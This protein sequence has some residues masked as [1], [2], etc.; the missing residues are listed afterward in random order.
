M[1]GPAA[2]LSSKLSRQAEEVCRHYLSNG[3]KAG[4]YWLVGDAANTPGRSLYVRLYDG[5]GPA[6]KWNDAAT[7]EHG[8]LI[9]IIRLSCGF[10][11][12]KDTLD[13]ARRFLSEPVIATQP[14]S[15]L[16]APQTDRRAAARKLFKMAKPIIG[17]PA[18]RYLLSRALEDFHTEAALRFHP[19]CFYR[20][21][22]NTPM[23]AWPAL[24]AAVTDLAG[25]I[26]GLQRTWITEDGTLAPI[27]DHRRAMGDL[28]GHAVRFGTAQSTLCAGEGIETVL[29][30]RSLCPHIPAAAALTANHLA[31]LILPPTL[32]RL[33]IIRDNDP[34]GM[35]A[36]A[37]L[38]T[39][40][41]DAN[42]EPIILIPAYDDWNTDLC[43]DG[44]ARTEARLRAALLPADR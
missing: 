8:D 36:A 3:R 9:D 35:I 41:D 34:A 27:E 20:A 28:Q 26:T 30:I 4:R 19:A 24:L 40:A 16:I 25:T 39:T 17:T 22:E 31:A 12:L 14:R 13:E 10:H 7:G 37:K 29:S 23:T 1:T 32:K 43:R 11:T 33:Y 15:G 38:A 18:E 2:E 6:G 21:D 44:D 5:H 42:I